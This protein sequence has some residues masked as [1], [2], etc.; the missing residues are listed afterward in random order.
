MFELLLTLT[1][2]SLLDSMSAVPIAVIPLAIILNGRRPILGSIG[3]ISGGFVTYFLFGIL[4]LMGIDTFIDKYAEMFISYVKSEPN[5]VELVIQIILGLVMIYFASQFSKKAP[6]DSNTRTREY[7]AD[8]TPIQAFSISATI[9]I[10][11]MWGA[12]PYFAAIAQILKANLETVPM[13]SSLVYY[14]AIFALPLV[15]FIILRAVLG[16][17]AQGVLD[18]ITRFFT[19]WGKQIIIFSLYILGPLLIADGIGWFTGYPILDFTE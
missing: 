11:G 9:N 8:I 5:C 17:R 12:L 6:R 16:D 14:N 18:K 4:L 7:Q 13:I 19:H 1:P 10:I 3:F 15:G 2:I